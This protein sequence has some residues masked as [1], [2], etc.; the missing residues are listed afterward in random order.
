[1]SLRHKDG[2]QV[3]TTAAVAGGG[4]GV[5]GTSSATGSAE[6]GGTELAADDEEDEVGMPFLFV[7]C[8]SFLCRLL[9][10]APSEQPLIAALE[11]ALASQT[12]VVNEL[13]E[14]PSIEHNLSCKLC[15]GGEKSE[16]KAF[17]ACQSRSSVK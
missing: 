1:M 2:E 8:Y 4:G 3:D 7:S 5:G 9:L 12:R 6:G 17:F 10:Q 14:L 15:G 16:P 13:K 11:Q